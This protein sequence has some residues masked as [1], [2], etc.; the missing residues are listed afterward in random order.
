MGPVSRRD[1]E[2]G[3]PNNFSSMPSVSS[4]AAA[5]AYQQMYMQNPYMNMYTAAMM[6]NPQQQQQMLAQYYQML[7]AY[8]QQQ[9]YTGTP[10]TDYNKSTS[11]LAKSPNDRERRDDRGRSKSPS[12]RRS[13]QDGKRSSRRE[14]DPNTEHLPAAQHYSGYYAGPPGRASDRYDSYRTPRGDKP[15]RDHWSRPRDDSLR[16]RSHSSWRPL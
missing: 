7:S 15:E 1:I 2:A 14:D 3:K 13:N 11:E 6:S 12:S 16:N 5:A 4:A 10:S 8:Q 9:G